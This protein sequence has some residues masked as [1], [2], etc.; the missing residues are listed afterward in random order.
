MLS[1][2][3][4]FTSLSMGRFPFQTM[5]K[6]LLLVLVLALLAAPLGFAQDPK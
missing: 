4:I 5:H 6:L 2:D 3:A 1:L